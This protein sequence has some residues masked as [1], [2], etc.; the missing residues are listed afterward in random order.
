MALFEKGDIVQVEYKSPELIE[1][2]MKGWQRVG[3]G[4]VG[5]VLFTLLDDVRGGQ[6]SVDF[7][8]I[9]KATLHSMHLKLL[10]RGE[11]NIDKHSNGE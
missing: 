5:V 9:G 1:L 8:M 10:Q 7:P 4:D 2:W 6:V 3:P 11:N